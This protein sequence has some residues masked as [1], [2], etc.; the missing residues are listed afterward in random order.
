MQLN[1]LKKE[2][3]YYKGHWCKSG[4]QIV[5]EPWIE[6][7]KNGMTVIKNANWC[8]GHKKRFWERLLRRSTSLAGVLCQKN[9]CISLHASLSTF[10]LSTKSGS[11]KQWMKVIKVYLQGT[12]PWT[13][14]FNFTIFWW[15]NDMDRN[16]QTLLQ[17][18]L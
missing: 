1:R 17:A 14:R 3:W 8:R 7:K 9:E 11:I 18:D 10:L 2:K 13:S 6:K 4:E 12:I 15:R 5:L 16:V